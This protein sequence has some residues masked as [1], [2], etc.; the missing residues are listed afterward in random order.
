MFAGYTS[1]ER[2]TPHGILYI[3]RKLLK[4]TK[5]IKE[6][7]KI[8]IYIYIYIYFKMNVNISEAW[9]TDLFFKPEIHL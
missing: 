1:F 3:K 4:Y 9:T 6:L 2:Y 5:S 7:T 8:Y